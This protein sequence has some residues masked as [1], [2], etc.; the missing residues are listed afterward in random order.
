MSGRRPGDSPLL[1]PDYLKDDGFWDRLSEKISIPIQSSF[2]G[3]VRAASSGPVSIGLISDVHANLP[4]L[5]AVLTD[6]ESRGVTIM[7]NAGDSTGYGP[8]PDEVISLLRSRHIMSVIGNYDLSVLSKRWKTGKPRSR[9]KQVAM[10]WAY[11][12]ISPENLVWLKNLPREIR[13][14]VRG[15]TLLVTHGSPDSITEYLDAGTPETRLHEVASGISARVVVTGHS[16]RPAA[17]EVDGVWF[18][19]TGSVGRSEDG[20]PRACYALITVD[21]FSLT[22]IRVPYDI[23]R[24]VTALRNRHLPDAFIRIV[25]EGRSLEMVRNSDVPL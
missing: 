18:V 2:N 8:F 25:Q 16:H 23:D 17:R 7:L 3:E 10:R 19:N 22:H 13:L 1:D 5:E 11:H 21:P 4:A 20:D 6:A 24:T 12:N 14:S 9:E 15:L